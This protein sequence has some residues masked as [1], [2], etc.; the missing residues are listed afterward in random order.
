MHRSII[1]IHHG[2]TPSSL[3]VV[4]VFPLL[5]RGGGVPSLPSGGVVH[6]HMGRVGRQHHQKEWEDGST[7]ER[8]SRPRST[9]QQEGN[10]HHRPK[11]GGGET[12]LY[13]ASLPF[14]AALLSLPSFVWCC[15]P[16]FLLFGVLVNIRAHRLLEFGAVAPTSFRRFRGVVFQD[17]SAVA[18]WNFGITPQKDLE[19]WWVF[20]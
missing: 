4:A 18:S 17:A 10:W 20:V 5:P 1:P 8:R 15:F 14:W 2:G 13:F 11:E 6:F 19:G 16:L 9:P 12:R 7:T 3:W